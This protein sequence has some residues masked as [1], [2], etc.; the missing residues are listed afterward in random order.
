MFEHV[1]NVQHTRHRRQQF[2]DRHDPFENTRLKP[3]SLMGPID[4]FNGGEAGSVYP[5]RVDSS[6]IPTGTR[7]S[8]SS[9][10]VAACSLS[11][12]PLIASSLTRSPVLSRILDAK[13]GTR[14]QLTADAADDTQPSV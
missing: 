10:V 2:V 7:S 12:I 1:P 13:G 3:Q 8:A 11:T 5:G 4:T 14:R 6:M 9:T